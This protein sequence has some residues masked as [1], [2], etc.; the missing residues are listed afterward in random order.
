MPKKDNIPVKPVML[1]IE[2]PKDLRKG[3]WNRPDDVLHY[4]AFKN[5]PRA[6]VDERI[7]FTFNRKPVAQAVVLKVEAPGNGTGKYK[8]WHKVY[9][10][11]SHFQKFR[12]V[13]A[14]E[15]T[16]GWIGPVYHGSHAG[17]SGNPKGDPEAAGMTYFTDSAE[18]AGYFASNS[19]QYQP[20]SAIYPAHIRLGKPFDARDWSDQKLTIDEYAKA[21]GAT[22]AALLEEIPT[23]PTETWFW[24]YL[25]MTPHAS[26]KALQKQ[27]YDSIIQLEAEDRGQTPHTTSFVVFNNSQIKS[28]TGQ[29]APKKLLDLKEGAARPK[30]LYHNSRRTNRQSILKNGLIPQIKEYKDIERQPAVFF[31][32]SIDAARDYGTFHAEFINQALDI[33]ECQIPADYKLQP[34]THEE[35]IEFDAW[36]SYEPLP[37]ANVRV[38]GSILVPTRNTVYPPRYKSGSEPKIEK[39]TAKDLPA[40]MEAGQVCFPKFEFEG[41]ARESMHGDFSQSYVV[42]DGDKV[43]GAYLLAPNQLPEVFPG[44]ETKAYKGRKGI[45]GV[46]LFLLPEYRGAGVGR[47][48]RG[49]PMTSNYDYIWGQHF[50]DLSNLQNWVNFGRTHLFTYKDMGGGSVHITVMDIKPPKKTADHN[51]EVGE[52]ETYWAGE[53]NAA[54][55]ILPICPQTGNVCLAMRSEHVMTPGVWGTIGGAVQKGLSPQQSAKEELREE[56]GYS[57]GMTLIPAFV[58]TDRG[59]SYHNFIGVTPT[60]FSFAPKPFSQE[61][62]EELKAQLSPKQYYQLEPG[63]ETDHIVWLPYA[64]VVADMKKHPGDYHPGMHKL[65]HD[66]RKKIEKELGIEPQPEQPEPPKPGQMALPKQSAQSLAQYLKLCSP[67]IARHAQQIYDAWDQNE[68]GE[69]EEYGGGGI[70]DAISEEIIDIVISAQPFHLNAQEGGQEGDDH[71]WV[72]VST[73][74]EVYGVDIPHGLYERGGGYN[75]KKVPG[76]QFKA[77]DVEIWKIDIDPAEF[78]ANMQ[79]SWVKKAAGFAFRSFKKLWHVGDMNPKSKQPGSLEGSG[80]SVSVHPEDWMNIAEIGGDT[81]ELT[82]PSNR[83]LNFHRLSKPQRK[84]LAAWGIQNGYLTEVA[85]AYRWVYWDSEAEEERYMEFPTQEEAEAEMEGMGEGGKVVPVKSIAYAGTD[86]LKQRTNNPSGDQTAVAFDLLVTVYAEEQLDCDGVWWEDTYDPANL[87]APRGVIFPSKLKSWKARKA[88][89]AAFDQTKKASA[90]E[91]GLLWRA[92]EDNERHDYQPSWDYEPRAEQDPELA[93][94]AIQCAKSEYQRT[95]QPFELHDVDLSHLDAVAMY[96][97]GT[98]GYPV[99]LI[100]L[101]AHRGEERQIGKSINHELKHAIQDADKREY[102]EE[103]A[104]APISRIFLSSKKSHH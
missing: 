81:W 29:K 37:A 36:K 99:V 15:K 17:F 95:K 44:K 43:I 86:K 42:K 6:F 52:G 80:L 55:G 1:M 62:I 93:A 28:T 104:E 31:F 14:A 46:A 72:V 87:S 27:G 47:K 8:H 85:N 50:E 71:S 60:E 65:F 35:M 73:D 61:H 82:K 102:D 66:S 97:D 84:Q 76:V 5:R 16:A 3:F 32:Q 34:D 30:V 94:I 13:T 96:I 38:A 49:M 101:E 11:P 67:N 92:P 79:A 100:D 88:Q 21:I 78:N 12:A 90:S 59:F 57:G 19:G 23:L 83:F 58:F 2:V 10:H 48:L 40:V 18:Y 91:P 68:A 22:R 75:W 64:D 7:I 56:T 26:K 77:S 25:L 103:E 39:L 45:E 63:W 53:G 24:R 98:C 41:I 51:L 54:S 9:W 69:D 70:C 89:T 4:W 20:N 33:W 74:T